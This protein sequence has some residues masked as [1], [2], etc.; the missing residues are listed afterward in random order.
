MWPMDM[1]FRISFKGLI[2][3]SNYFPESLKGRQL[4]VK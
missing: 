4:L 3:V 2:L 1:F